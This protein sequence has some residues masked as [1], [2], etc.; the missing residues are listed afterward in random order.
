MADSPQ[1]KHTADDRDNVVR[2]PS[3]GLVD[4]EDAGGRFGLS[5]QALTGAR[6]FAASSAARAASST[7]SRT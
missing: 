1:T 2:R 6:V 5:D 4:C 3:F 7:R